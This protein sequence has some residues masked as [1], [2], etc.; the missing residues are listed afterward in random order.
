MD[1]GDVHEPVH[2]RGGQ[3]LELTDVNDSGPPHLDRRQYGATT[4]PCFGFPLGC[5]VDVVCSWASGSPLV[6]SRECNGI[7]S[8]V[9]WR[10]RS[11]Y[12]RDPKIK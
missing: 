11:R 12:E 2:S 5:T 10:S 9:A 8:G 1:G 4:P 6:P 7:D 3:T